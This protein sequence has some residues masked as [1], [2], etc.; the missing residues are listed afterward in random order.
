VEPPA[1]TAPA[2][3]SPAAQLP[4]SD[5]RADEVI[6]E[7]DLNNYAVD[8]HG[9]LLS[10]WVSCPDSSTCRYAWRLVRADGA[11]TAGLYP[12]RTGG[13]HVSAGPDYFVVAGAGGP[14]LLVRADGSTGRIAA[15]DAGAAQ[16]A[17][18]G[19]ADVLT[20]DGARLVDPQHGWL[21]LPAP[22]GRPWGSLEVAEDGTVWGVDQPLR[23]ER[24]TV[25]WRPAGGDWQQE[26][27]TGAGP[28]V[29]VRAGDRVAALTLDLSSPASQTAAPSVG[30]PSDFAVTTDAGATWTHEAPDRLP[31]DSL[32][33]WAVTA[34]GTLMVSDGERVYRTTDGTWL[35][36]AP[37][38]D[39]V[40][41]NRLQGG[42]AQHPDRVY[43]YSYDQDLLLVLTAQGGV[44]VA[45]RQLR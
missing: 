19:A 5:P 33:S 2:K 17:E 4:Q 21:D 9:D 34:D 26:P 24:T 12:A 1:A 39:A 41:L 23:G 27:L 22:T 40:A 28:G 38:A 3:Q 8:R 6:A 20:R 7:G 15:V 36:F 45:G 13:P 10:T 35:R 32:E 31:F 43:G 16:S 11:S 25:A 14:Q 29:L 42:D 18:P 30:S 44:H 37:V